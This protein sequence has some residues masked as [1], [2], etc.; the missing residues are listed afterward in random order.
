MQLNL[1]Q[2]KKYYKVYMIVSSSRLK[3]PENFADFCD[4]SERISRQFARLFA[5]EIIATIILVAT[6]VKHEF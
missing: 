3:Q 6:G 5:T 4:F 1:T 2:Q